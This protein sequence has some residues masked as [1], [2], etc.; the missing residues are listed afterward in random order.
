M[1]FS[2]WFCFCD[3]HAG[4]QGL[5]QTTE[6]CKLRLLIPWERPAMKFLGFLPPAQQRSP[7]S[8]PSLGLPPVRA[9]ERVITKNKLKEKNLVFYNLQSKALSIGERFECLSRNTG[10][11]FLLPPSSSNAGGLLQMPAKAVIAGP[12][13]QSPSVSRSW[14]EVDVLLK[15]TWLP[16]MEV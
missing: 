5:V 14:W 11:D 8:T 16:K 12:N 4:I 7:G 15:A 6:V 10:W 13:F 2:I 1:K 3:T 9:P